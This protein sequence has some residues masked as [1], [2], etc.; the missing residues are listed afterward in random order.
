MLTQLRKAL[1]LRRIE[2]A[3]SREGWAALPVGRY[4]DPPSWTYS[5]GF[6]ETL[7]KPEV[8]VFDV[9]DAQRSGL[10]REVF[11][12]LQTGKLTALSWRVT[13]LPGRDGC[14]T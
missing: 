2:R 7:G 4:G 5:V 13:R 11:Q 6:Q 8:I 1:Y 12:G 3:V 10:M 9:P 14:D